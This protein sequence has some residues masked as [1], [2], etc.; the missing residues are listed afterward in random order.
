LVIRAM[1]GDGRVEALK[2]ALSSQGV[3]RR[4]LS[5]VVP[6]E[7]L[8]RLLQPK[9]VPPDHTHNPGF[10]LEGVFED[11]WTTERFDAIVQQPGTLLLTLGVYHHFPA[12]LRLTV[13]HNGTEQIY[14]LPEAGEFPLKLEFR[15]AATAHFQASDVF[16]P[17]ELHEST[18]NRLLS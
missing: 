18:D 7:R 14:E 5:W 3:I 6:A 11:K 2:R 12:G 8:K 9:F 16:C 15:G 17:V 13:S 1:I 4:I 10:M